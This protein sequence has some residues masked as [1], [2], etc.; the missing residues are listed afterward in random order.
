MPLRYSIQPAFSLAQIV[1]RELGGLVVIDRIDD[2]AAV[3]ARPQSDP[4]RP[5]DGQRQHEAV[6]VVGMLADQIDPTRGPDDPAGRLPET[7]S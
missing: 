3:V 4:N 7:A 2:D 6:V 5:I 1:E